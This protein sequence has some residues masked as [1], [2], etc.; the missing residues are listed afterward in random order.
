VA[1]QLHGSGHAVIAA[2]LTGLGERSHLLGTDVGLGTHSAD[3]A[4]LLEYRD[5]ADAV[6]VGHSYGGVVITAAA[7]QVPG[8]LRGLVY[9][10]ASTPADGQSNNDVLGP[11]MAARL[12]LPDGAAPRAPPLPSMSWPW[13][14]WYPRPCSRPGWAWR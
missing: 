6:L 8:R 7:G 13:R 1:A 2:T 9:L 14:P 12:R 11:D 10:D 3:V 5:L 4:N